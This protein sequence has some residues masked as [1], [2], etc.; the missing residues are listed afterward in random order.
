VAEASTVLAMLTSSALTTFASLA[1]IAACS[2]S[3]ARTISVFSP[4]VSVSPAFMSAT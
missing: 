1:A 4:F 2:F 3:L